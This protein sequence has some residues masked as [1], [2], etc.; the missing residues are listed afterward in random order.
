MAA[1]RGRPPDAPLWQGQ[2]LGHPQEKVR[3]P[4]LWEVV[5]GWFQS[6]QEWGHTAEVCSS[7]VEVLVPGYRQAAGQRGLE[8]GQLK[9]TCSGENPGRSAC[10][11]LEQEV[12]D[13]HNGQA[14]DLSVYRSEAVRRIPAEV[15]ARRSGEE[16]CT[17][18]QGHHRM[19]NGGR[20]PG[21]WQ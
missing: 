7:F 6:S 4:L 16:G 21:S 9:G 3:G 18:S 14:L 11:A 13:H 19:A 12:E 20:S 2:A 5:W 15:G 17:G 1:W 8:S 10:R